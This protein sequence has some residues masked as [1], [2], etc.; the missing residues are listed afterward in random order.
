MFGIDPTFN[1]GQVNL[2]IT[3]YK[4][5]QLVKSNGTFV[6]PSFLQTFLVT[7]PFPLG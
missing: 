2:T 4:Q 3:N 1:F 7:I 5:L 6:G